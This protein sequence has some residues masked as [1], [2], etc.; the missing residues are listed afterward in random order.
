MDPRKRKKRAPVTL[1]LVPAA[2]VLKSE[3]NMEGVDPKGFAYCR[4]LAGELYVR[5]EVALTLPELHRRPEFQHLTIFCLRDWC[6][7]DKWVE[8]R[9]SLQEAV[10]KQV[11]ASIATDLAQARIE[12]LRYLLDLR[13]KFAEMG[14]IQNEKGEV[15][16]KLE[17]RSLESWMAV[18][19][20]LDQHIDKL[21]HS[22]ASILPSQTANA[23]IPINQ[24]SGLSA[25]LRPRLS[26]EESLA[27][28]LKLRDMRMAQDNIEVA[29]FQAEQENAVKEK[30]KTSQTIVNAELPKKNKPPA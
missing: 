16:F 26:E 3:V 24:G 4:L 6:T 27:L 5:S 25:T 19:I 15:N 23:V 8:R 13:K 14:T 30:E 2:G 12:Q 22:V 9:K 7:V 10:R 1:A 17:P 20:K 21:Q 29:K 11:E 18:S 28:A